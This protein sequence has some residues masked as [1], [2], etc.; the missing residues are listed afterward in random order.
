MTDKINIEVFTEKAKLVAGAS[1]TVDVLIRITPP[2]IDMSGSKRPKL[3]IGVA[4]DRS[5]SMSGQKMHQAREAAKYCVDQLLS[6]DVFSTVIFDDVVDVLFTSQ[7]ASD[8][9][10]LKRG[11]DRIEAR[12]STDLHQA[13]VTAGLQ[14]SEKIDPEAINRVLLITD[15]Q[16]NVGETSVDR[17]VSQARETAARG[18]T[19][20]TIGIGDDFNEDLLMPMAEAGQGNAWHVQEPGDMLKIFETELHGLV[21]QFAHTVRLAIRPEQGARVTDQLNDFEKDGAGAYILPNMIAASPLEMI[22]R[23]EVPAGVSADHVAT[24]DLSFIRQENGLAESVSS[25]LA[26]GFDTREAVDALEENVDVVRVMQVLMNA[27][28]R[29][30]AMGQMDAGD[31]MAARATVG[32]SILATDMIYARTPSAMLQ[33]DMD[34]LRE[35]SE[36]LN[37]RSKDRMTRKQMSYYRESSRKGKERS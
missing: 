5:G 31:Y 25:L 14:V 11:I 1:Q 8:K 17:I 20:T 24:F 22:V 32:S 12:N 16:A 37:D 10:M 6:T 13:W 21:R 19:T 23:I 30:E 18:V 27:R 34:D 2:D 9:E 4:L 35:M 33:E 3:N 26:P 29:R 7:N 28:A 15:G 36:S